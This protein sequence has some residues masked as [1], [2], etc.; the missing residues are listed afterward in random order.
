MDYEEEIVTQDNSE[1]DIIDYI[2]FHTPEPTM[3]VTPTPVPTPLPTPTP[4]I[5]KD[6]PG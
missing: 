4:S 5:K 2:P 6:H 1:E 3:V